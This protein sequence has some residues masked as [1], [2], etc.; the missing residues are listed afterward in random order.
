MFWG[1]NDS[2]NHYFIIVKWVNT[3]MN[4]HSK[5]TFC[6]IHIWWIWGGVFL[7]SLFFECFRDHQWVF[8]VEFEVVFLYSSSLGYFRD[9][10]KW[11]HIYIQTRRKYLRVLLHIKKIYIYIYI[12]IYIWNCIIRECCYTSKKK[13]VKLYY[14]KRTWGEII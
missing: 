12:Y 9:H 1:E 5:S 4:V 10:Q 8:Y 6:I 2:S 11:K 13:K 14:I 7:Y 3:P